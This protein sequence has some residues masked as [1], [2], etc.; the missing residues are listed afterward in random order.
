MPKIN[1]SDLSPDAKAALEAKAGLVPTKYEVYAKSLL[2]LREITVAEG[3]WVANK[4]QRDLEMI[5]R[6]AKDLAKAESK[7]S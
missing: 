7:E 2:L 4:L 1:A 3:V 5:V 6:D